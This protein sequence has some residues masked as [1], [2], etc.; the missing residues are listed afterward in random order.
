MLTGAS[1]KAALDLSHEEIVGSF[2]CRGV[3]CNIPS[4]G[5]ACSKAWGLDSV[6]YFGE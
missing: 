2:A 4:R 5:P 1:E 3:R 6:A